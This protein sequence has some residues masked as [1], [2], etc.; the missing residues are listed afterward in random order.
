MRT[1][2]DRFRRGA[3]LPAA[4][5]A[6]AALA[7]A[8]CSFLTA[9][10]LRAATSPAG[11]GL[12]QEAR[13]ELRQAIERRYAVTSVHNGV[14][15]KPHADFK[16]VAERRGVQEVEVSGD[17]VTIN[18]ARLP[19]D[20]VRSW[21]GEAEAVPILRLLDLAPADRQAL[22]DLQ[23]DVA[24][25]GAPLAGVPATAATPATT[26]PSRSAGAPAPAA[27]DEDEDHAD[28]PA[29]PTAPT[30]PTAPEA[31]N[32][33][34]A[35]SA[36]LPPFPPKPP[37]VSEGSQVRFGRPVT[38]ESNEVA[39]DVAA[40]G[41]SVRIE[42]EVNRD[43]TA[44]G[45][46]VRVN[47][48]VGGDVTA[49]GGSVHLGPHAEVMGD[50]A[51]IGGTVT[52]AHGAV[53]HGSLSDVGSLLPGMFHGR[54]EDWDDGWVMMAPIGR[55]LH[56]FWTLAFLVLLLLAV[57]LVV[58]LAPRLLEEVRE[59]IAR[60]PGTTFIAGLLGEL[61]AGPALGAAAVLLI[62]TIVGCVLVLL[63]PFIILALMIAALVGFSAAA[64]QF[65]RVLEGRFNR[66]PGSPYVTTIIGVLAI[67]APSIIGHVL[68][69]GGGML[70][71]FALMFL[72]FGFL[73]RYVAWTVGFGAAI[74][75]G[76][77]NRPDRLRRT[78]V[79]P[80]SP[81]PPPLPGAP[82]SPGGGLS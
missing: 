57:S 78:G 19:P 59:R 39:D 37:T 1:P 76:F 42:G 46:P 80:L 17:A 6:A 67:E 74:L 62:I 58:L 61:L 50:V 13:R 81:M 43:V 15:L 60:E 63:F 51:A 53:V 54:D 12:S 11:A 21:I 34:L 28:V 4:V 41:G 73:V 55:S 38:I 24:A 56:L 65:G 31:L 45:G 71:I 30:P 7:L 35:P 10:A 27:A 64:Y 23:R 48:R 5:R 49:V 26:A 69:V 82:A 33:P 18:G 3:R 47:G 77:A 8:L 32:P 79:G 70:H 16:S 25:P 20:A 40:I 52:R 2:S 66:R 75:T 29:P 72:L 22:F 68:A 9:P 44:V 36:P 14:L